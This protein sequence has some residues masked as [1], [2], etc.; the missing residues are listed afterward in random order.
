MGIIRLL[1]GTPPWIIAPASSIAAI[2]GCC[3]KPAGILLW[4]RAAVAF[5]FYF[6]LETIDLGL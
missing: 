4:D 5:F 2:F 1:L 6:P 3:R